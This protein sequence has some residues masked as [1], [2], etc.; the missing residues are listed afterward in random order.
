M[1]QLLASHSSAQRRDQQMDWKL[2]VYRLSCS[3]IK[4]KTRF[5]TEEGSNTL[6]PRLQYMEPGPQYI[7]AHQIFVFQ[8]KRFLC[9]HTNDVQ[10]I[11]SKILWLIK[12]P[13]L[14]WINSNSDR[15]FNLNLNL[16][17]IKPLHLHLHWSIQFNHQL[18]SIFDNL[19]NTLSYFPNN[20]ISHHYYKIAH[21]D[22]FSFALVQT[23][24]STS[25]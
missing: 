18:Q 4:P 13:F 19:H 24:N 8:N 5:L 2:F 11:S 9:F 21:L 22:F 1:E 15:L 12:N 25:L 10:C 23:N 7:G 17:N 20:M 14:S 3:N 16:Y 6:E